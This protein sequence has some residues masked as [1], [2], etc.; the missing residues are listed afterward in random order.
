MMSL[1]LCRTPW[2]KLDRCHHQRSEDGGSLGQGKAQDQVSIA[3]VKTKVRA[4]TVKGSGSGSQSG[5]KC[6]EI[7]KHL[8]IGLR[9]RI[10]DIGQGC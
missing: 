3:V 9:A 10:E 8:D 6:D 5:R 7:G 2:M 4:V 1:G